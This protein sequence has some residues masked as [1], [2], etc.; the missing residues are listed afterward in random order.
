MA[1]FEPVC[2]GDNEKLVCNL[3]EKLNITNT[4]ARLLVNRGI[5][6]IDEAK[7]FLYP[8]LDD[9]D[10]PFKLSDMEKATKRIDEAI[11]KHE[12]IT[13]Y[14]DYDVD[15]ITSTSI[16]YLFLKSLGA[17][18]DVY[19]PNRYDEGYGLN[20]KA[21][22]HIAEIGSDLI[23]TVDC[24]I[25][26]FEEVLY[27]NELCVDI[28]VTDHHNI[29]DNKLPEAYAVINPKR[30]S[31]SVFD[32]LAGVGVA[33]KIIYALGGKEAV[34]QYIDIIAV[35]TIA[36]VV[37]LVDENRIL[38]SKG[39]QK[40]NTMPCIGLTALVEVCNLKDKDISAGQVAFGLAP[41]LNAAGRMD[42]A[43][44]G[45]HLITSDDMKNAVEIATMLDQHNKDRQEIEDQVIREAKNSIDAMQ[46]WGLDKVIVIGG[47]G[48]HPGV[49]GI[50][51]SKISEF[52]NRPTLLI[53][54]DGES[55]VGSARSIKG[56]NIYEALKTCHDLFD[57]FGGHEFA[58]GF[59]LPEHN[60]DLLRERL[61]RYAD[62]AIS[63]DMLI[64]RYTYDMTLSNGDVNFG[65]VDEIEKM[66]P[67]GV[68]NP[69]PVFLL[70]NANIDNCWM[71]GKDNRHLK[72]N[73]QLGQRCWDGIAF[74]MGHLND[75]L[76]TD[77]KNDILVILEK[78]EWRGLTKLQFQVKSI[79]PLIGGESY[80]DGI[81]A[82]FYF[83]FFDAF[84]S[85]FLYNNHNTSKRQHN[86]IYRDITLDECIDY[87]KKSKLG[88]IFLVNNAQDGGR[89]LNLFIND[90]IIDYVNVSYGEI[91]ESDGIGINSIVLAPDINRVQLH[92]YSRIFVLEQDIKTY[93]NLDTKYDMEDVLY[94]VKSSSAPQ[95][96]LK[97][98]FF[99]ERKHFV[100]LYK[101]LRTYSDHNIWKD[102]K[103]FTQKINTGLKYKLNGFQIRLMLEVFK[104]LNFINILDKPQCL[105]IV[106]NPCPSSRPLAESILYK[107]YIGWMTGLQKSS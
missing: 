76:K 66:A 44:H 103:H 83:K 105:K 11:K 9:L 78:N 25:N 49:I 74:G 17:N 32:Q 79:K 8:S 94:V 41:R 46:K 107:Y 36:D 80:V 92:Y 21:I 38:V 57:R 30:D 96:D 71:V 97:D 64:P 61:N 39:L 19:I 91:D 75:M 13:I 87:F 84:Y 50:A 1:I 82:S 48:W 99:V 69:C 6:E 104:E 10:D 88:N 27:A 22:E 31:G 70:E 16:L 62:E 12:H 51:A 2:S 98:C 24:G 73:I 47:R 26:A 18:V 43:I 90:N 101:W 89:I 35:G 3:S 85:N 54:T 65:L 68:G 86:A 60:I 14:G 56:F 37:P 102:Y 45:F 40:L 81:L 77:V 34:E 28:I 63:D 100:Y 59:S 93:Y 52:Y 5:L 4:M 58:A 29:D 72:L 33:S 20:K 67:F 15:G 42:T 106:C 7:C 55:G 95:T 53:S 23:I